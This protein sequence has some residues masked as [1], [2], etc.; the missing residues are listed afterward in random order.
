MNR[1]TYI[2]IEG[3]RRL[4][5]V[6]LEMR[7]LTV[8]IGANGVG[9]TTVLEVFSL[10]A[11]SAK[12]QL[13]QQIGGGLGGML[14][15]DKAD[16][17][18]IFINMSV[19]QHAPLSYHLS[20]LPTRGASY[21]IIHETLTQKSD[22]LAPEPFKHIESHRMNI[23]YFNS[24]TRVLESPDWE[25]NNFETSL[26][27][28]PKMY[29]EPET[30]RKQLASC[31]FYGALDVSPRSPVRLPQEMRPAKLP[32]ANGEDLVSCLYDLRETEP[33]RFEIVE[34]TL[35]AAFP[36]FEKLAFPPVAAGTLSMTWKDKNFSKP[37]Y[38]HELSEGTLRFLWLV[39]LLQSR[40]LTAVT[41]IDEPEVSLHP[42]L[43]KL[44]ADL[45]RE[46]SKRTQLIVAT[47]SDRLIRFLK[48]EE[49]LVC[50][51]EDG[52]L[53]VKWGDEFNLAKWLAEYSLDEIWA[54]NLMGGR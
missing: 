7:D 8:M 40:Q 45:M 52:L 54:M 33:E 51:A 23:K 18:A 1:F 34:D 4:F 47:H 50:D 10:L 30:L 16:H 19:P 36:D 28:V 43:L 26:S 41:L 27:Q 15:R 32:G 2:K 17:L 5:S 20:I 3:F 13:L 25:H 24:R 37:I 35:A 6:E 44:L 11:A 53:T 42:D 31:T 48:P 39:A 9:K 12:G 22:P 49:V 29:Q 46:A 38:A 14:T 21:E